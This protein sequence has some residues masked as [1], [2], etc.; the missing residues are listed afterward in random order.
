M[1]GWVAMEYLSQTAP[2]P[3]SKASAKSG[4]TAIRTQLQTARVTASVLNVRTQPDSHARVITVLFAGEAVQVLARRTGWD[5]VKL[6]NG[7]IGW[8]SA[9]WLAIK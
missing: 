8:A 5:E 6:R 4:A 2:T 1:S 7:T 3:S 9:S